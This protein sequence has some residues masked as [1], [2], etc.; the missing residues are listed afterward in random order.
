MSSA[1]GIGL[2]VACCV[3]PMSRDIT[4]GSLPNRPGL[5]GGVTNCIS[6]RR[7]WLPGSARHASCTLQLRGSRLQGT[8]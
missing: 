3:L 5:M 2:S 6:D 4:G 7:L 1:C 8:R